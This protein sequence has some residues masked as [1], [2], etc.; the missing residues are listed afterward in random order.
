M[1]AENRHIAIL[2]AGESGVGAAILAKKQGWNVFVSDFGKI[3]EE[4][5]L[6]LDER[7]FE[8]EEGQHDEER[9]LK[10]DLVIKSPGIP[11]KA[12]CVE[13]FIGELPTFLK[14]NK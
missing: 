12:P 4:F 2:G 1:N 11:D 5:K 3:K 14:D 8:W 10:A 6:Q 9:I 7:G 13:P